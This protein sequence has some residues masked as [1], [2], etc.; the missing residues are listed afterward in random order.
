MPF[1]HR[2]GIQLAHI[3]S[4]RIQFKDLQDYI[5]WLERLK[6]LDKRISQIIELARSGL[7]NGYRAPEVLM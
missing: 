6:N 7:D 5:F 1:N 2:G 4:E 3:G